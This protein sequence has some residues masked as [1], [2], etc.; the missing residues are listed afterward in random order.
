[1]NLNWTMIYIPL[2]CHFFEIRKLKNFQTPIQAYVN[3]ARVINS[4]LQEWGLLL[5]K[6][7][8]FTTDNDGNIVLAVGMHTNALF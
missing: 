1:M 5:S 2:I 7:V 6:V 4:S 3:I 8:S